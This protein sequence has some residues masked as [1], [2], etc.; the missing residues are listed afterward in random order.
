MLVDL[1]L[2]G[3]LITPSQQRYKL[4]ALTNLMPYLLVLVVYQPNQI[5]IIMIFLILTLQHLI[6]VGQLLLLTWVL[7]QVLLILPAQQVLQVT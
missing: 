2:L 3:L 6:L 4:M 7:L 1:T 5:S